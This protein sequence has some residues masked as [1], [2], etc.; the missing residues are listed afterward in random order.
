[1]YRTG[2]LVSVS[3]VLC[4]HSLYIMQRHLETWYS[5][6]YLQLS[7]SAACFHA[8]RVQLMLWSVSEVGKDICLNKCWQKIDMT[9]L[10]HYISWGYSKRKHRMLKLCICWRWTDWGVTGSRRPGRRGRAT[11]HFISCYLSLS[12]KIEEARCFTF[13]STVYYFTGEKDQKINQTKYFK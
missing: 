3:C 13:H 7:I 2:T 5:R 1:M 11:W 9:D 4:M 10:L 6:V 12:W 8:W